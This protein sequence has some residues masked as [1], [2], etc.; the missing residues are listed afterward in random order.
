MIDREL[1]FQ[2]LIIRLNR[3]VS[4]Y[5]NIFNIKNNGQ[6]IYFEDL[7]IHEYEYD[8]DDNENLFMWNNFYYMK[9]IF[10]NN[11]LCSVNFTNNKIK[12]KIY[13]YKF[14]ELNR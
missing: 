10:E 13:G 6:S 7:D 12:I 1:I 2:G 5:I 9:K 4:Q 14:N 8:K 11:F 3:T